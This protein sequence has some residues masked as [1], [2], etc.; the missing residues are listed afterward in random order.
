MS[1]EV[2]GDRRRPPVVAVVLMLTALLTVLLIAFA[3]PAARSE[4]RNVPLAVAGPAPAVAQVESGLEQAM[5]GGFEVTAVPD[6]ATAVQKIQDRDVYGA[7]VLDPQQPELLTASAALPRSRRSSH[8]CRAGCRRTIRQ[9]S[10][11][12][13]HCRKTIR[14]VPVWPRVHCRSCSVG[15]SRPA[16]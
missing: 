14:G 6:R 15:S 9:S 11:T 3:W 5:P 2:Q 4:P 12:S 8:S 1:A 10:P 13:Y 7:I 16:R